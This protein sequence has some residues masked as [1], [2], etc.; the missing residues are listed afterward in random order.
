MTVPNYTNPSQ[1]GEGEQANS[2][3]DHEEI[4]DSEYALRTLFIH[5]SLVAMLIFVWIGFKLFEPQY[6]PP[7]LSN[8]V[9]LRTLDTSALD[10]EN[11]DRRVIMVGDLHGMMHSFDE[12]MGILKY[13]PQNDML[14]H[15]GDLV[16][17]GPHSNEL[18]TR[19]ASS[20]ATGVRGNHDQQVIEWY[21][22]FEWVK[23]FVGGEH[24]LQ[25][26]M[27]RNLSTDQAKAMKLWKVG[28]FRYS[29]D[30]EWAGDHFNIARNL[31]PSD[32][33]Y[34]ASLPIVM[35]LPS[36]HTFMVHAG[37]LPLDPAH[38]I[39]WPNQPL[40][41]APPSYPRD[42]NASSEELAQARYD[43]E[44]AILTEIEPNRDPFIKMNIRDV[45]DLE[46]AKRG[47]QDHEDNVPW[48]DLWN[49]VVKRCK[50]FDVDEDDTPASGNI[51]DQAPEQ[52]RILHQ[53]KRRRGLPC[54]PI[55]VV[56][57]HASSRGLDLKKWSKGLDTGCVNGDGLTA[58]IL[59]KARQRY[60]VK[61]RLSPIFGG[62]DD[63]DIEVP[64][65]EHLEARIVSVSCPTPPEI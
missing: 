65:G 33:E 46:P 59:G 42:R 13:D 31:S 23:S 40:A 58:L 64:F 17:K 4:D 15:L 47:P 50:G 60:P 38:H 57:S 14:I 35:H 36:L 25:S 27:D 52:D 51:V 53:F 2:R 39:R 29:K 43:Q 9:E 61:T 37:L 20:N 49:S 34:L 6:S 54:Y 45:H 28:R 63:R 11:P 18:V 44:L 30:W 8:Y 24:W 12:L 21:A 19:F 32:Y 3:Q 62:D 26:L 41:H 48:S 55:T 10:L 16:A 56:Y 7:D 1:N 5:V 22:W